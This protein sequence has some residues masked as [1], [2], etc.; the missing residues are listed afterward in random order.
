MVDIGVKRLA[1]S[2]EQYSSVNE[3]P[4]WVDEYG[5]GSSSDRVLSETL[6]YAEQ[7]GF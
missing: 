4:V 2:S 6:N 5:T 1:V 3:Q 7:K